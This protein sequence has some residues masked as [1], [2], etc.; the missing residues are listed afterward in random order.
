VT[1]S[2]R[3]CVVILAGAVL[4][5]LSG[6]ERETSDVR[7]ANVVERYLDGEPA[8]AP[9]SYRAFRRLEAEGMG[10]RG[11]LEAWTT[12]DRGRFDFEVVAEGGS[13][14]IR[15]R[16]L[17]KVLA[18]EQQSWA[19]GEAQ[20]SGVTGTNYQFL[21][22]A[23]QPPNLFK[24]LLKPRHDDKMLIDGW[25]FLTADGSRLVRV[26]GRL[27]GS[28]SFWVKH[29]DVTRTYRPLAGANMLVEVGS[30]ADLRFA[31]HGTLLMTYDYT[32]VNGRPVF[33]AGRGSVSAT[34]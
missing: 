4:T 32:H 28:P 21:P 18:R 1:T 23:E 27:K 29:V 8:S 25:A 2:G 14:R 6:A 24:V 15:K 30:R 26:E 5:P 31:G 10:N 33:G 20:R 34:R 9:V 22:S 17:H 19:T 12:L 16:V 3:V 11:W 13:E 7:L